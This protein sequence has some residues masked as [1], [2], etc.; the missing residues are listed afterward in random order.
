MFR[1]GASVAK[2]YGDLAA[3]K[4]LPEAE[5]K[6]QALAHQGAALWQV[7]LF[8]GARFPCGAMHPILPELIGSDVAAYKD[9]PERRSTSVR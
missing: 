3:S 1:A 2:K 8:H 7:R 9:R 4:A 5:A 6:Q